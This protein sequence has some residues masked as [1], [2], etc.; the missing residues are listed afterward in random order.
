MHDAKAF[1]EEYEKNHLDISLPKSLCSIYRLT[2]CIY[3][4]KSQSCYLLQHME[5][6][7][8]YLLKIRTIKDGQSILKT[9]QECTE[10]LSAAF[11]QEYEPAQYLQADGKEYFLRRYIRGINLEEY[12]DQNPMRSTARILELILQLCGLVAQLHSLPI[13]IIHR[14]IKPQNLIIDYSG[15]LHLI[16]FETA[17]CFKEGQSRDTA[18]F[19]TEQT[20]APEQYGYAQTD[21]RTDVYAIGKVLSFL[22]YGDYATDARG[23]YQ[24]GTGGHNAK[25]EKLI[26]HIIE[27]STS[28]DPKDRY[29]DVG[30]MEKELQK[31]LRAADEDAIARKFKLI[32]AAETA[33]AAAII[34][35]LVFGVMPQQDSPGT[36][37]PRGLPYGAVHASLGGA[38]L[39]EQDLIYDA[40]L[41]SLDGASLTEQSL[42][43][44]AALASLGGDSLTE[45]D[46]IY[47]A[48]LASLDRD[49]L[50]KQSLIYDAA[51][52]SLGVDSLTEQDLSRVTRI[53]VIG[54]QVYGM[55]AQTEELQGMVEDWYFA[56]S[57]VNGGITD[58]SV[59][60]EM[61]NLQEVF[62]CAQNI[63]DIS[64]LEGLPIRNLYLCGN[65]IT[66]LSV[67]STLK[68]L[69]VLYV[70]DNP[71]T[72]LPPLSECPNLLT[73]NLNGNQFENLSFLA[74]STIRNLK[75][76]EIHVIEDDYS[77]LQTM[78]ELE[79]VY[80][81]GTEQGFFD[82][83]PT[84]TNLRE[85]ALW[86]YHGRDLTLLKDLSE[87]ETIT[88]AGNNV[89]SLEGIEA[90][91]KLQHLSFDFTSITDISILR[92]LP[93]LLSINI[94]GLAI[95]DYTPILD[96]GRLEWV[97]ADETQ[98][99]LIEAMDPEHS[100]EI[101][102]D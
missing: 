30:E 33:A 25:K 26:R 52:A 101:A 87:L 68:N 82:V 65:N 49:S 64:A 27:K 77:A 81:S 47:G 102:I 74:N 36:Y 38:S 73:V 21:Q 5:T 48:A 37:H 91:G 41:A 29:R 92:E 96:C 39:T 42:I 9:E 84:L 97:G 40:A 22:Y 70:V 28:F 10:R 8:K 19:G 72:T 66:D 7:E 17:R 12:R 4:K 59:L 46:L 58:I 11:P 88:V 34:A 51:L 69:R 24:T 45:Q 54:N 2:A 18:F 60:A 93:Q 90:L 79:L 76:V 1:L 80:Y 6:Q 85:I 32:G 67:V 71:L 23:R 20:A 15:R 100:Y 56:D 16:D 98:K 13:P 44:D 57:V 99:A 14:D 43:Y 3:E 50:T 75:I 89:A 53:A 94:S 86:D 31:A 61:K 78:K 83:V 95:D 35:V 62:L 63:S 55:D